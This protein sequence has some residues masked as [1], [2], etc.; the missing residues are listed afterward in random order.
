VGQ[1]ARV[2]EVLGNLVGAHFIL[3]FLFRETV[4]IEA[5]WKSFK[6]SLDRLGQAL[7][8]QTPALRRRAEVV[9]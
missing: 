4:P 2:E 7:V 3:A 6:E 1:G 9:K 5:L 8:P